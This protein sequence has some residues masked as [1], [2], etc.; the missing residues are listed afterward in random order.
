MFR[1][2]FTMPTNLVR[3]MLYGG[4]VNYRGKI[5]GVWCVD[6]CARAFLMLSCAHQWDSGDFF[7]Q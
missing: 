6:D 7:R 1:R 5:Y 4:E 3:E 2:L